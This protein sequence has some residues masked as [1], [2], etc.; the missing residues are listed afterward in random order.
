MPHIWQ[1][2]VG[3]HIIKVKPPT[4]HIELEEAKKV[5]EF[6]NIPIE[7]LSDRIKH[8]VQSCFQ[9]RRLVCIFGRYCKR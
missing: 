4:S 7:K 2:L 1:L 5:Y 9:G 6:E 3:A 8:V